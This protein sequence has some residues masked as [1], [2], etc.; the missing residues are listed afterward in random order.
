MLPVLSKV[1]LGKD[2]GKLLTQL[3]T[4]ILVI[5]HTKGGDDWRSP[6]ANTL[7]LRATKALRMLARDALSTMSIK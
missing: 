7:G 3:R 4:S 1:Q 6:D 2:V 5:H